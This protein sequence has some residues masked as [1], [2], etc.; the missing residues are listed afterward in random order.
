MTV[1]K[2]EHEGKDIFVH[3]SGVE[4]SSNHYKYLVQGEYVSFDVNTCPEDSK[5][6]LQAV[7]VTGVCGNILMCETKFLQ[8][9]R[10]TARSSSVTE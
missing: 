3:H 5:Y 6:D 4:T 2:G 10:S 9:D 1:L 8:K 7:G